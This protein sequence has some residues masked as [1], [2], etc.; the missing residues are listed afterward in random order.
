LPWSF[1]AVRFF[2]NYLPFLAAEQNPVWKKTWQYTLFGKK[3]TIVLRRRGLSKIFFPL[4]LARN[5]EDGNIES[6]IL[7]GCSPC[8]MIPVYTSSVA[9]KRLL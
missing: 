3:K 5:K 8:T 9:R 6:R 2:Y 1:R 4:P 7:I